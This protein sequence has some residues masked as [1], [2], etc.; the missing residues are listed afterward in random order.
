MT[1]TI[2]SSAESVVCASQDGTVAPADPVI[3]LSTKPVAHGISTPGKE[4][5]VSRHMAFPENDAIFSLAEPKK[6]PRPQKHA[7]SI[8]H[9]E[10]QR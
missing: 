4:Q 8:D 5:S 3:I 1:M 7:G 6:T 9:D 2:S 10:A